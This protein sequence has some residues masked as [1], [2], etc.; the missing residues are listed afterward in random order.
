MNN[1]IYPV[2][3]HIS[4]GYNN[5]IECWTYLEKIKRTGLC[6]DAI[7]NSQQV[8][9]TNRSPFFSQISTKSKM[10]LVCVAFYFTFHIINFVIFVYAW[11][12]IGIYFFLR[13]I[14][15]RQTLPLK[16]GKIPPSYHVYSLIWMNW[17]NARNRHE[18]CIGSNYIDHLAN[19]G[20]TQWKNEQNEKNKKK[21]VAN[22]ETLWSSICI[23]YT[24]LHI[25]SNWKEL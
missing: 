20:A 23:K 12:W 9:D 10:L 24:Y 22:F 1:I 21:T 16:R 13:K 5:E 11:N 3:G 19:I 15:N 14:M 2:H 6:I 8:H 7:A 18:N 25:K 4:I 17:I